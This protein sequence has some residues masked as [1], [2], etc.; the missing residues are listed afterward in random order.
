MCN[1]TLGTPLSPPDS[2]A[3]FTIR[4]ILEPSQTA[5]QQADWPSLTQQP[6]AGRRSGY[7]QWHQRM[8]NAW[9]QFA[10]F[11][12]VGIAAHDP[13]ALAEFYRD[14]LGDDELP[15]AARYDSQS[16]GNGVPEQSTGGRKPRTGDL[17]HPDV[18]APRLQGRRAWR[19]AC[20]SS[21]GRG[22]GGSRSSRTVNH[23]CS[24]AF[25]FDDPEGN[26]I[27]IYWSTGLQNRQPYGDA[28]DLCRIG[29]GPA[30]ADRRHRRPRGPP[31]TPYV[32]L[33]SVTRLKPEG[34]R[35]ATLAHDFAQHRVECG[36]YGPTEPSFRR[37][38]AAGPGTV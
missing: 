19:S 34:F 12:H 17:R 18:P 7:A 22:S 20:A 25:Y 38:L 32:G 27:E 13:L 33:D 8:P 26:M 21:P 30:P 35:F 16:G 23:G 11:Y 36:A 9:Q 3:A 1:W 4:R 28:L 15:A 6:R 37:R 10:G 2:L 14:V 31:T 24:F 5:L 29:R